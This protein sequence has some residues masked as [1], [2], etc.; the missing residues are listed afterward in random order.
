MGLAAGAS[1]LKLGANMT[2]GDPADQRFISRGEGVVPDLG[3]GHPAALITAEGTRL[4]RKDGTS[5]KPEADP[6]LGI[7]VLGRGNL[8]VN[9]DGE[10]E[11]LHDLPRQAG[12]EALS[13]PPLASRK[14]PEPAKMGA[15][16][17]A[18]NQD[19]AIPDDQASSHLDFQGNLSH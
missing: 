13:G 19:L 5:V 2:R 4:A 9:G 14:L 11:L 18:G 8:L 17:A 15:V 16:A 7:A 3:W 6:A 10:A 12:F 1:K